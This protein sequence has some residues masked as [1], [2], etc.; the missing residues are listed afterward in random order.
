MQDDP[1]QTFPAWFVYEA[2]R[3]RD[4]QTLQQ[5]LGHGSRIRMGVRTVFNANETDHPGRHSAYREI[6]GRDSRR[7]T[8][9]DA[10]EVFADINRVEGNVTNK[11]A[12]VAT[13]DY[14]RI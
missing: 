4:T 8:L 12:A 2:L 6:G 11:Y 1:V 7:E 10:V 14:L 13:C 9:E 3:Q 5:R